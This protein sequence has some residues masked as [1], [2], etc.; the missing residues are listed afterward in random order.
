MCDMTHFF[1]WHDSFKCVTWLIHMCDMTHSYVSH[2]LHVTWL[3][4]MIYVTSLMHMCTMTHI[5][6]QF[7]TWMSHVTHWM[8]HAAHEK[9]SRYTYAWV[10]SHIWMSHVTHMNESCHTYRRVRYAWVAKIWRNPSVLPI[11]VLNNEPFDLSCSVLQS[12]AVCRCV[13]QRVAVGWYLR[14]CQA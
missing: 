9:D 1:V 2:M 8:S 14:V 3:I 6:Y 5:Y 11:T 7:V 13:L 12:V 10:M 4:Y